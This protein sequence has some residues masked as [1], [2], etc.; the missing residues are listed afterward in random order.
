MNSCV[1]NKRSICVVVAQLSLCWALSS[2]TVAAELGDPAAPVAPFLNNFTFGL[3]R[4]DVPGTDFDNLEKW[5]DQTLQKL[6]MTEAQKADASRS[7]HEAISKLRTS[8]DEF[9]R[10][11]GQTLWLVLSIE[12]FPRAPGLVVVPLRPGADAEVLKKLFASQLPEQ[13]GLVFQSHD[14]LV[15]AMEPS[16]VGG[17]KKIQSQPRPEFSKAFAAAGNGRIMLAFAPSDDSRRVLESMLP[18]LPG[19]Q[20]STILTRGLIWAAAGIQLPPNLSAHAV[21]QSQDN[22]AAQKLKEFLAQLPGAAQNQNAPATG[23]SDAI[24]RAAIDAVQKAQVKGDQL[25]LDL[26]QKQATDVATDLDVLIRKTRDRASL[27]VSMNNMKQIILGCYVYGE[28]HNDKWPQ[29]LDELAKLPDLANTPQL[30]MNPRNPQQR[31]G[32]VYLPPK[33]L[34]QI[35][36]RAK[37]IVLYES[38]TNWDGGIAVGY[39]DGHVEFVQNEAEFKKQ[40]AAQGDK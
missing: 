3:I 37:H 40:L 33:D 20:S 5:S 2:S 28:K 23:P 1:F 31:P 30:F 19:G 14:A 25:V 29:S 6:A 7:L 11:G 36:D 32:Y 9:T 10:A 22:A 18:H 4:I 35:K 21:A 26:D 34:S 15:V 8:A 17:W 13:P 24:F 12:Q 16:T 38:H 27:E 39:A